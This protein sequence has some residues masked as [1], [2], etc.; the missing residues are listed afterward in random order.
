M[1]EVFVRKHWD[2]EDITFILHFR[3]G[4]AVAQIE[5]T[6]KG[7]VYLDVKTPVLGDSMLYDQSLDDLD[8][9]EED[10]ISKEGFMKFWNEK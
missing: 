10:Y 4:E 7:K 3:N 1:K 6:P 5:L 8:L 9:E 2:E